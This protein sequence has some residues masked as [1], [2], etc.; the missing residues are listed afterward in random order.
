MGITDASLRRFHPFPR[1]G[2]LVRGTALVPGI[3]GIA[4]SWLLL[5]AVA[6]H[7]QP[8]IA[9]QAPP[10]A[11]ARVTVAGEGEPGEPLVVRGRILGPEGEPVPGASVF[12]YQTGE[13]GIYGPEGNSN[14]RLKGY[15]RTDDQG[16]WEIRTIRP[17]SYPGT[18]VAAHIHV[19]VAPPDGAPEKVGEIVFEGDPLLTS[20]MRDSSFFTV[21]E[22][23]P[24][25]D[26]VQRAEYTVRLESL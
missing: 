14:P 19:H 8:E 23:E 25:E 10:E 21:V 20:R 26:G 24:A 18:R 9:T 17:G 6:T 2:S 13:D 16:R 3:V 12:V 5:G 22:P 4:V 11:P 7:A 15:L 1:F